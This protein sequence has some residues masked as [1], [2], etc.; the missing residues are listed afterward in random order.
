MNTKQ[1]KPFHPVIV[2]VPYMR[3][4]QTVMREHGGSLPSDPM[5]AVRQVL[6]LVKDIAVTKAKKKSKDI[7]SNFFAAVKDIDPATDTILV[8]VWIEDEKEAL[9]FKLENGGAA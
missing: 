8:N 2:E 6:N 1:E 7:K 9:L 5:E 3:T 4:Y